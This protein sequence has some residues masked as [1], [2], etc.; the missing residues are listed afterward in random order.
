MVFGGAA[1]NV[2]S[3]LFL[4]LYGFLP[5]GLAL[6]GAAYYTS[7]EYSGGYPRFFPCFFY[8][9]AAALLAFVANAAVGDEGAAAVASFAAAAFCYFH[10]SRHELRVGDGPRSWGPSIFFAFLLIAV[11]IPVACTFF[12]WSCL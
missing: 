7:Y 6:L 10:N 1:E 11:G 5:A 3:T 4:L 9:S 12:L 8:V 2:D